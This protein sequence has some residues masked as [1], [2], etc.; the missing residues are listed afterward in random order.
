MTENDR[1]QKPDEQVYQ[2]SKNRSEELPSDPTPDYDEAVEESF[3]AS[4]P[5]S[6]TGSA[7]DGPER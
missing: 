7:P 1:E 5:P 2:G 3:P 6:T 4:D